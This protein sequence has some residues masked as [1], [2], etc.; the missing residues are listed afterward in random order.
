MWKAWLTRVA[1]KQHMSSWRHISS[2]KNTRWTHLQWLS[3]LHKNIRTDSILYLTA[4][5]GEWVERDIASSLLQPNQLHISG[6]LPTLHI[7]NAITVDWVDHHNASILRCHSFWPLGAFCAA[8]CPAH[9]W[10]PS[11]SSHEDYAQAVHACRYCDST[12]VVLLHDTMFSSPYQFAQE[13]LL[14][15]KACL[16]SLAQLQLHYTEI[17]S[18]YW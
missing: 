8:K 17:L 4:I 2:E 16:L 9:L 10:R 6:D 3:N 11:N 15:R 13:V 5:T 7:A 1:I 14:C 18:L 12:T